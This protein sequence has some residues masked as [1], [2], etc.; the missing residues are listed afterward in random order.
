MTVKLSD[1]IRS[2]PN[3]QAFDTMVEETWADEGGFANLDGDPGGA[4][5]FGIT[6]A[7]A[8]KH[9]YTGDMKDLPQQ[10]ALDI[11]RVSYYTGP[12]LDEVAARSY[13]IAQE[14][15]DAGVNIG[16]DRAGQMLQ[17]ALNLLNRRGKDWADLKP[18]GVVGEKTIDALTAALRKR[19]ATAERNILKALICQRGSYYMDLAAADEK[20]ES[21][22][23]GWLDKRT[24]LERLAGYGVH[25]GSA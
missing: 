8:R 6:E 11:Y 3:D 14:C 15:F 21:F 2:V 7:V 19:G 24:D 20:F 4:T 9:G 16:P 22:L 25:T 5:R 23:N 17:R 18:D 1:E 10:V 12:G 13:L